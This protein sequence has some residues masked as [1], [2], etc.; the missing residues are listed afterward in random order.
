[1]IPP[2]VIKPLTTKAGGFTIVKILQALSRNM[3]PYQLY[4]MMKF[5]N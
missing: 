3:V 5:G 4:G 1:M 2:F